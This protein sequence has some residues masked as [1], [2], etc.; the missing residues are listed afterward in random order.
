MKSSFELKIT[1]IYLIIGFLWILLSGEAV[2]IVSAGDA[3]TVAK[4]EKLKGW[5][6]ILISGLVIYFL[7]RR[8]VKVQ[9]MLLDQ[10]EESRLE[11]IDKHEELLKRNEKLKDYAYITSHKLRKP[12][13]NILGL[14]QLFNKND[15]DD[16]E[17][18]IV[19]EKMVNQAEELDEVVRSVNKLVGEEELPKE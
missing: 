4:L 1:L 3:A 12:L 5:F 19:I 15:L 11:L 13:A 2:E 16:P 6:F 7:I 10:I 8:E 14:V 17:N 9:S 18:K